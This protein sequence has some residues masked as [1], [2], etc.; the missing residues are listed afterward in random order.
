M[1]L[2]AKVGDGEM[3]Q[4]LRILGR[5]PLRHR[6][7]SLCDLRVWLSLRVDLSG[8]I[9]LCI[10]PNRRITPDSKLAVPYSLASQA[11]W[12]ATCMLAKFRE[13]PV[14]CMVG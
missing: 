5:P 11:L 10:Y 3:G 1:T 7:S 14:L 8:V 4:S 9:F 12:R 6:I 2:F 13:Q